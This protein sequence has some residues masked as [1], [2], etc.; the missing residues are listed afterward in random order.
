MVCRGV[1]VE[2]IG[3]G[4]VGLRKKCVMLFVLMVCLDWGCGYGDD[5]WGCEDC[6]I[7]KWCEIGNWLCCDFYGGDYDGFCVN[8]VLCDC[9]WFLFMY[10]WCYIG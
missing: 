9:L 4:L 6:N 2:E 3:S 10:V 7:L 1:Y 8:V 5:L